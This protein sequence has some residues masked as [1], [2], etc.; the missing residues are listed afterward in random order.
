MFV[1]D[2]SVLVSW[3][4]PSD[5]W[6]ERSKQWIDGTVTY[7]VLLAAPVVVLPEV[8]GAVARRSRISNLGAQAVEEI[9]QLESLQLVGIDAALAQLSGLRAAELMMR[10]VD[11]FYV[12]VAEQL[13]APLVTWDGEQRER[14]R[15]RVRVVTPEE[16][17]EELGV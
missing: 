15:S 6:H 12:A 10:G 7:R 8:A 4:F 16:G 3:L 1:V 13:G 5:I 14:G 11:A 9:Q 17:M 2:A